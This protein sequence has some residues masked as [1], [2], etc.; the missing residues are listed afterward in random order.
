MKSAAI[1]LTALFLV[2][3][4]ATQDTSGFVAP[5]SQGFLTIV[6]PKQFGQPAAPNRRMIEQANEVCPGA[7]YRQARPS[8][9][10]FGLY[11][12]LFKC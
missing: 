11:D 3:C 1:V 10:D 4:G 5:V 7:I 6:G 12:Y 2:G 9:T 8:T